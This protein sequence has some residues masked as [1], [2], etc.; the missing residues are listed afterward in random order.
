MTNKE[1]IE[2]L[3]EEHR[4]C[5]EPCYVMNAIKQA[6]IALQEREERE[7]GC[8]FCTSDTYRVN[9]VTYPQY[10]FCPMCGRKLKGE[11]NV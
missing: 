6:I 2:I 10:A 3:Q 4:Y 5:L 9:T 7:R 1:A 8:E 11:K